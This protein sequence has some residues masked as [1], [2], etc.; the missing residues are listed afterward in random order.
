MFTF[1]LCFKP[2]SYLAAMVDVTNRGIHA[3]E[4]QKNSHVKFISADEKGVLDIPLQHEVFALVHVL[5]Q[6]VFEF[7]SG[8]V[9]NV[10]PLSAVVV[11]WLKK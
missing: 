2:V 5:L 10:A 6:P 3:L 4:V 11:F 1:R 8:D 9:V 7:L